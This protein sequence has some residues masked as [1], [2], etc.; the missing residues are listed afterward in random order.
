MT[1]IRRI[2]RAWP[3][4]RK[5]SDAGFVPIVGSE[6]P[7]LPESELIGAVDPKERVGVT[8][9]VRFKPGSPPLPDPQRWNRLSSGKRSFYSA[10]ELAKIWG[11]SKKDLDAVVG[12]SKSVGLS[13][14][15]RSSAKHCVVVE[16]SAGQMGTAFGVKL[17]HY[18]AKLRRGRKRISK[19]QDGE[20]RSEPEV[21][22][23]RGFEGRIRIPHFLKDII[24]AVVG[25]DNRR[26]GHRPSGGPP[27]GTG[28]P[29]GAKRVTVQDLTQLYNFPSTGAVGQ[30]VGVFEP[31]VQGKNDGGGCYLPQDI[32]SVIQANPAPGGQHSTYHEIDL[33][34]DGQTFSNQCAQGIGT[35]LCPI[36]D[37][38]QQ[39]GG[40]VEATA[41]VEIILQAAPG[42]NVNVYFSDLTEQ[43]WVAFLNRVLVPEA[44]V[45]PSVVSSSW[46]LS[47]SDDLGTLESYGVLGYT[48]ARTPISLLFAL[49]ACQGITVLIAQGD[50]GA[51]D[52]VV[53]GN[54]H[55][56][57]P[58]TDP[59]VT[60]CG[61]TVLAANWESKPLTVLAEYVW[62][63][64]CSAS[65][66]GQPEA[67]WGATGGGISDYF[68][69]PWYQQRAAISLNSANPI[70]PGARR[71]V[72]DIAGMVGLHGLR[73]NGNDD[74]PFTGTSAVAPLYA[75][76]IALLN[77]SMNGGAAGDFRTGLLNSYLYG[78]QGRMCRDVTYG[79]NCSGD[80][81]VTPP[82]PVG[83]TVGK[84]RN[85]G[86][87]TDNPTPTYS[88]P[89][90]Y[91]AGPGW[92]P[93]S[94]WGSINGG[95]LLAALQS[96]AALQELGN[97][98]TEDC[99]I[100][101][102]F[103]KGGN[104]EGVLIYSP[105]EGL[106]YL[107]SLSKEGYLIWQT[108][109]NTGDGS[110]GFGN[111]AGDLFWVGDFTGTGKD[112]VLFYNWTD[113][114]WWLGT[115]NAQNVL[116]WN[117]AFDMTAFLQQISV[118][119][120]LFDLNLPPFMIWTGFFS[121]PNVKSI[122][123]FAPRTGSWW[124]GEFQNDQFTFGDAPVC[125]TSG[126]GASSVDFGPQ[127]SSDWFWSGD[128]T[129]AGTDGIMFYNFSDGHWWLGTVNA[130]GQLIWEEV[131]NTLNQLGPVQSNCMV[132]RGHFMAGNELSVVVY[133]FTNGNWWLG[134]YQN[135]KLNFGNGPV[136]NTI[137]ANGS[138]WSF[139]NISGDLFWIGGFGSSGNDAILFYSV[140]DCHWWIGVFN[141]AG[142]L[143]WNYAGD[144][145]GFGAIQLHCVLLAGLFNPT[146][147]APYQDSI[148]MYDPGHGS[149]WL[150]QFQNLG[151][152]FSIGVVSNTGT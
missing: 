30:T 66:F 53:D 98:V 123:L 9:M 78:F 43:G 82:P 79:N 15:E 55:V 16:G 103:F 46:I 51:D 58:G 135:G 84:A 97:L 12:F 109:C 91:W 48:T 104:A 77:A 128:F 132:W 67:D 37:N 89:P 69:I 11:S 112:S 90:F 10:A 92:D 54:V 150:G 42:V 100:L 88:Y 114:H 110:V 129:G 86:S 137:G 62:S 133:D 24:T 141:N 121:T 59:Y 147:A 27:S 7:L 68:P 17:C 25:L 80:V 22:V 14:R 93:C 1:E 75:G 144:T 26:F 106:W 130:A 19:G 33:T 136:C 145:S 73:F 13:V 74:Y 4:V 117:L 94:G 111:I 140:T 72:P 60:S 23:Y 124:L 47:P 105:V 81:I 52:G 28:D 113:S 131:A 8:I 41:D 56:S 142:Q 146:A 149:W 118:A 20:V 148:L 138:P 139:G 39:Q 126:Q 119:N 18:R 102:G 36:G 116:V 70:N 87:G 152:S 83:G 122:L 71:G 125:N 34:V 3:G 108:V 6:R 107:G 127:I 95:A 35:G 151:I 143:R 29:V 63:D 38:A 44:E 21:L 32:Q 120:Q 5:R 61:G 40:A 115:L 85:D 96:S 134:Q 50:R 65:P 57:Y 101:H 76:L 2:T 49:L 99:Q 45:Q 64:T 31:G